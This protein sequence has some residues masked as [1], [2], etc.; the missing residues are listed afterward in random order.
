M[1]VKAFF[2]NSQ[3]AARVLHAA[4]V[5]PVCAGLICMMVNDVMAQQSR[6]SSNPVVYK[7]VDENGRVTYTN[8]PTKGATIVE[9]QPLTVVP[10]LPAATM[11]AARG[12]PATP[13]ASATAAPT[14]AAPTAPATPAT[15]AEVPTLAAP[16]ILPL[17][18]PPIAVAQ[19][20]AQTTTPK[21]ATTVVSSPSGNI[22]IPPGFSLIQPSAQARAT[23]AASAAA[24]VQTSPNSYKNVR[25]D[26]PTP[27]AARDVAPAI[28][29]APATS[30]A[31]ATGTSPQIRFSALPESAASP[32]TPAPTVAPSAPPVAAPKPAVPVAIVSTTPNA[33]LTSTALKS[34]SQSS[35]RLSPP[36]VVSNA[37][38][39]TSAATVAAQRRDDVRRRILE[40][41]IEAEQQ[42]LAD[43]QDALNAEQ[44]KSTEVRTLRTALAAQ[45]PENAQSKDMLDAKTTVTRHFQRVRDLQDQIAMHQ[46]NIADMQ[47][48]MLSGRKVV[49]AA[50]IT[51]AR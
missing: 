41:E 45:T 48:Q 24:V 40:G 43:A 6:A 1:N 12:A 9:L 37:D 33:A 50:G 3:N 8:T 49:S 22:A 7:V 39:S 31:A 10:G 5:W 15:P 13:A 32:T 29:D 44:A 27:R 26:L 38:P 16:K 36:P 23:Q 20:P 17:P 46:Q 19:A 2:A 25:E 35:A 28:N 18:S 34:T 30:A 47:K 11:A 51:A 21:L 4:A 42:L 14:P